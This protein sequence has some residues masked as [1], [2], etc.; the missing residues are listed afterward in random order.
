MLSGSKFL[1]KRI[2]LIYTPYEGSAPYQPIENDEKEFFIV[3]KKKYSEGLRDLSKFKYICIVYILNR[4]KG[5]PEMTIAPPWANW[6]KV[7]LFSSR[8]PLRP[9]PIGVSVVKIKKI[10]GNRIYISGADVFNKTP[11]LDIKPYIKDLDAKEDSNNGWV[12][13]SR[14][15][16]HLSLHVRG[17]PHNY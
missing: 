7:G 4:L 8:S 6:K 16:E 1:L 12:E 15:L 2:G 9:N 14:D 17:I 3:I 5:K 13:D 10:T 11:L